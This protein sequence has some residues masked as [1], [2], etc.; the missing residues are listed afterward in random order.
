MPV[1]KAMNLNNIHRVYFLG[2]GG[3][4]MSA[5]ARYFHFAGK[6][7]SGYDKV[8]TD[9]TLALVKLG[10]E[11]TYN[12]KIEVIPVAYRE[13]ENTLIILTPAI[14]ENHDQLK[15]FESKGFTIVKRA[16]VL[17]SLF[18]NHTGI[19]VAGTHGKTTVSTMIAYL[20]KVSGFDPTAFLGGISNNFNSNLLI[21]SDKLVV[22]EADEFDRSFLQL[23]PKIA[24]VTAM[25]ADHLDIYSDL[26]DISDTFQKFADQIKDAGTLIKKYNLPITARNGIQQFTYSL[27]NT[28]ADFYAKNITLK[29]LKYHFTLISPFGEFMDLSLQHPGLTNVENAI[30]ASAAAL[31]YTEGKHLSLENLSEFTGIKRRFDIRLQTEDICYIDDYAHHPREIEATINSA[32]KL[33]PH[34]KITGIF[35]PHLYTRTR[36]FAEEFAKSLSLLDEL[37]ILDIYPARELPIEGVN[38]KLIMDKVSIANRQYC[39][40]QNLIYS[41]K[42]LN[43]EVLLTMG[44]GDID[45]LVK[46]IVKELKKR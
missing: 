43:I 16:K 10:I 35:Q 30:A 3:I 12:E 36:D 24:L 4:G 37:I 29:D 39:S 32:R 21:G 11:V 31:I 17:G 23:Q 40:K 22:A 15:Y 14:P 1:H 9:I 8:P 25:D 45:Q 5:L 27:D 41:L 18:N 26:K 13:R 7:V 42:G 20:L 2:I 19:A 28:K 33:F 34:K 38:A 6:Q 46:P 44:A